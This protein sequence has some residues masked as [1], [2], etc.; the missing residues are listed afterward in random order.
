M[1]DRIERAEERARAL[2]LLREGRARQQIEQI[3]DGAVVAGEPAGR[4]AVLV[5][6][7]GEARGEVRIAGDAERIGAAGVEQHAAV[8]LLHIN[9][10]IGR[11]R[12]D[13]GLASGGGPP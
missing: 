13:L 5:A 8:E 4:L 9:V 11:G 1:P 6:L 2:D 10:M 3:A 7:D 12:G